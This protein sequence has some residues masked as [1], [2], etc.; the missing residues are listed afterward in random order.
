[1]NMC[2]LFEQTIAAVRRMRRNLARHGAESTV[3]RDLLDVMSESW[4]AGAVAPR[5]LP[6]LLLETRHASN[7]GN[8][9]AGDHV[10]RWIL[11]L[12][13]VRCLSLT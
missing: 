1:M 7:G 8:H 9:M 10:R 11:G 2:G 12:E 5:T 4:V 3:D 13:V 6:A